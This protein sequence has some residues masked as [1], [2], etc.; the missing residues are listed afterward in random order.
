M[1]ASAHAPTNIGTTPVD[2]IL[3]EFKAKEPGRPAYPPR[4]RG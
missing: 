1:T 2:A 3:V 4:A